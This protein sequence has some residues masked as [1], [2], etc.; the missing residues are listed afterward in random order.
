[1]L[2]EVV[3][4]EESPC[5]HSLFFALAVIVRFEMIVAGVLFVAVDASLFATYRVRYHRPKIGD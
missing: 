4:A 5:V 3:F 1:M 2:A